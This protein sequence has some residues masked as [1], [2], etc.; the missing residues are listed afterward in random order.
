[1]ARHTLRAAAGLT[2][3]PRNGKVKKTLDPDII[4]DFIFEDGLFSISVKNI[5]DRSAYDVSIEFDKRIMGVEG[6]KEITALP[7]FKLITFFAPKKEIRAFVDTSLSYFKRR[8]PTKISTRIWY[9]N[10][11]GQR[12]VATIKHDLEIYRDLGYGRQPRPFPDRRDC[13]KG[14]TRY[15]WSPLRTGRVKDNA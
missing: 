10:A 15:V 7:V 6:T 1:M 12:W 8:Q 13:L 14:D 3:I 5:S 11:N 4:A 9:Q 2:K